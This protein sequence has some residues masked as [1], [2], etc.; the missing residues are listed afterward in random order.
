M[1]AARQSRRRFTILDAMALIMATAFGLVAYRLE[2]AEVYP[3]VVDNYGDWFGFLVR[4]VISSLPLLS[5]WAVALLC[6]RFRS[7]R[8]SIRSVAR[9]PGIVACFMILIGVVFGLV[10]T[11][12]I[13]AMTATINTVGPVQRVWN[14]FFDFHF[15][16]LLAFLSSHVGCAIVAA[17]CS[18]RLSRRWRPS[19]DWIDRTGRVLGATW[20]GLSLFCGALYFFM[21]N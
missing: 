19:P 20:I 15:H 1:A 18:L 8:P 13:F 10:V 2:G 17:W 14:F 7:P 3:V 11:L 21:E 9:Q 12:V 4:L 16:R 6:L 5:A